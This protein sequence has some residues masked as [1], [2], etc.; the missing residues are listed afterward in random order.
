MPGFLSRLF[1]RKDKKEG[2]REA[3]KS[4]ASS[5][6]GT[7]HHRTGRGGGLFQRNSPLREHNHHHKGSTTIISARHTDRSSPTTSEDVA[8][9][10][11]TTTTTTVASLSAAKYSNNNNNTGVTSSASW[12]AGPDR[13][14]GDQRVVLGNRNYH[15]NPPS[16]QQNHHHRGPVDLDDSEIDTDADE[17]MLRRRHT[18]LSSQHLRQLEKQQP[19][20]QPA[21][22]P[23]LFA[24]KTEPTPKSLFSAG[25]GYN[26]HQQDNMSEGDESSSFNVSTDAEDFEYENLRKLGVLPPQMDNISLSTSVKDYTTDGDNTVFPNLPTDDEGTTASATAAYGGGPSEP[27]PQQTKNLGGWQ[28]PPALGVMT[29]TTTTESPPQ[30]YKNYAVTTSSSSSN[31]SPVKSPNARA[32]PTTTT[33]T[34]TSPTMTTTTKLEPHRE[35]V[36]PKN[37]TSP[38][39]NN[40]D[41]PSTKHF[42]FD[43]F[44]DFSQVD[45]GESWPT[46]KATTTTDRRQPVQVETGG[47]PSSPSRSQS[48]R[49]LR[50]AS[51]TS[52]RET[53]LPEL[54]E[55]AKS[56]SAAK[57]HYRK[58]ASSVNSAPALSAAYLRE[59]HGLGRRGKPTV[60]GGS[61]VSDI[62]KNLDAAAQARLHSRRSNDA[63]SHSRDNGSVRSAKERLKER[64]AREEERRRSS[65]D[66][67]SDSDDNEAS[68]TWLFDGVQGA[69]G[70][71]GIAADLESLSVRSNRSHT[72]GGGRSHRSHKSHKSHRSSSNRRR[73]KASS[74]GGESVGSQGSKRSHGSRRSRSSRYS[75]RSTK[76]Y[77]SQMS[78][79]SRSV[80]NDLL[81]LEMQLAMVGN[82]AADTGDRPQPDMGRSGAR[83]GRHASGSAAG[84]RS[85]RPVSSVARRSRVTVVAPPGK[86]GIILAN[87]ADARGT[88]VS[89]VRTSSALVEKVSPGDRIVAIDGEDVSLMTVS[90]IT[91]IMARKSDFERTLTVLTSPRH[92]TQLVSSPRA[93]GDY[94]Y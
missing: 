8:G 23:K 74:S 30:Q 63:S 82:S 79:Q 7:S 35:F 54:L 94:R 13:S 2:G 61:S 17:N 45:F 76:S 81:R 16:P 15:Q 24:M 19:P 59:T 38:R 51:S 65:H 67:S 4:A 60:E 64:R 52:G 69:L 3:T 47:V 21:Q 44:A 91:T 56:K 80:A 86:L 62:I 68:E 33:T 5:G 55:L 27:T 58:G 25:M 14:D 90:E 32:L 84:G 43:D 75:H 18:R 70:P 31:S 12:G 50:S 22:P 72:S 53:S 26:N 37:R 39:R 1:R 48:S 89:G 77:I 11:G 78:E 20:P 41:E 92:S 40:D 9:T 46:K 93:S 34:T 57:N 10:T 73:N 42:G 83:S 85:N 29:T 36:S 6:T 71:R 66:D 88:V 28:P 49:H 87:K